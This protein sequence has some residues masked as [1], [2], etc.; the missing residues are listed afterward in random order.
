MVDI[1]VSDD[2]CIIRT[3]RGT[4]AGG[5]H[6]NKTNSA[7][8][9]THL[10]TGMV[11]SVNSGRSQYQ[12]IVKAKRVLEER[13]RALGDADVADEVNASRHEQIA[14]TDRS[15]RSFTWNTQRN[16]VVQHGGGARYDLRALMGGKVIMR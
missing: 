6:R 1:E 15:G 5:Q 14:M 12:N 16:E 11:V 2:D 13:L 7:V 9:L 4:G 3:K 8:Q 10:P